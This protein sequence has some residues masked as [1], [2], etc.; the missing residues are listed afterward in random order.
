MHI[1]PITVAFVYVCS[2]GLQKQKSSFWVHK[3]IQSSVTYK[4][5]HTKYAINK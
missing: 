3:C 2:G 1:L 5:V 4:F